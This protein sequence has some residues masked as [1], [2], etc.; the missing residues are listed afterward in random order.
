MIASGV[1][2]FV[3]AMLT[4]AVLFRPV[5][6]G[7]H[8]G[9]YLCLVNDRPC[10]RVVLT[11]ADDPRLGRYRIEWRN[12]TTDAI[13]FRGEMEVRRD[14]SATDVVTTVSGP[15]SDAGLGPYTTEWVWNNEGFFSNYT[16][17]Y[18]MRRER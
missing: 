14:G 18:V 6:L 8:G 4:A 3:A 2:G 5:D 7:Q 10:Y 11:P 9:S 17:E 15:D 12:Y 13:I 16:Q 1:L